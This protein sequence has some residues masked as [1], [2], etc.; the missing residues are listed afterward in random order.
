VAEGLLAVATA[1]VLRHAI[2]H[3]GSGVNFT[4]GEAAAAVRAAVPGAAIELGAG[5]EPWT[6]YTA[7]RGPL[8]GERLRQDTGYTVSHSLAA[9]IG[10]YADWMRANPG[11]WRSGTQA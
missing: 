5:T 11:L 2:Y 1:P 4:A 7:L 8:A 6:R 10:A 3:L 9:G